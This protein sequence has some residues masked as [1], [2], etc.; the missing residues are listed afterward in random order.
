MVTVRAVLAWFPAWLDFHQLL[1][2]HLQWIE[3]KD[4]KGPAYYDE[5]VET[6]ARLG[7]TYEIACAAS[8]RLQHRDD[9]HE[10]PARHLA[11]LERAI[12]PLLEQGR[13]LPRAAPALERARAESRGCP[14]C[15]GRGLAL[16]QVRL[17]IRPGVLY[18]VELYCRCSLGRYRLDAAQDRGGPEYDDLQARPALWRRELSHPSWSDEPTP[19]TMHGDSSVRY[20]KPGAQKP[21]P[22]P[23]RQST[24]GVGGNR[25]SLPVGNCTREVIP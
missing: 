8:K 16:R 12:P 4:P 11:L 1:F 22:G 5:W 3:W 21:T 15:E 13:H 9:V 17:A 6:F 18:T 10:C 2:V 19:A 24:P 14:E 23:T 20:L 7:A 25:G